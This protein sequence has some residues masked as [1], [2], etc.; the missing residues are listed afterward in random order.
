MPNNNEQIT[1]LIEHNEEL[2]NYF[3]NTIIPQLFID[4][5]MILRKFTPPAMKQFRL[6]EGDI[7][8]PI[9]NI[10]ENFRFPTIIDNIQEVISS[11]EILEK[12]IQT[13]DRHWYQMNI[14]PYVVRKTNKTNGVIIT[15]VDITHRINDLRE[16]EKLIGDREV[17]IDMLVHDIR[18]PL[19]SLGLSLELLK[20]G[21]ENQGGKFSALLAPAER[22]LTKI[23]GIIDDLVQS[24]WAENSYEASEELLDL[25]NILEDVRLTLADQIAESQ[26]SI[27]Y[28]IRF[29][30]ITFVRRNLRSIIYNL[31]SN[32]IKY[33][34]DK[35]QLNIWISS[36]SE[37]GFMVI[38]V[39]DNGI[40]IAA[41]N[42]QT[43][44]KKFGRVSGTAEGYGVGLYLV[45][46]M[47]M[48]TGGKIEV[49]SELGR[50]SVFRVYLKIKSYS[51]VD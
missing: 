9:G 27:S 14:L 6:H 2:E 33:R 51:Y 32:A 16:M 17:L 18:T 5:D 1:A 13:V 15:F 28:D 23:T 35:R 39:K 43:I 34:S 3:R 8:K 50:G 45:R 30:E 7:G 38:S 44:F 49:E 31:I 4:A 21:A 24:R 47:I 12:E 40:G 37:N 11:G 26:A 20:N 25:Q 48:N 46:E 10:K 41:E 19:T 22:S 36:Y 42:R 29:S